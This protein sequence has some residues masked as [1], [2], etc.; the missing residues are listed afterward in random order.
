M[1]IQVG[2]EIYVGCS[3]R[4][5]HGAYIVVEKVNRKSVVG[6]ER[7]GSYRPGTPWR[8]SH[9]S[10]LALIDHTGSDVNRGIET[11]LMRMHWGRLGESGEL[12][13]G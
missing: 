12:L 1:K 6:T 9:D 11:G 4:G 5:G 3:G 7:E 8:V 2:T 13:R 10:E